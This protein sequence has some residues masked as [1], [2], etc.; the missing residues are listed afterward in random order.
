[1]PTI[2]IIAAA[3]TAAI[4]PYL[5]Q[6]LAP[7]TAA[8]LP[9]APHASGSG[10]VMQVIAHEDDDLLFMN[11][12]V[13][14]SISAGLASVT[15][16]LTAGEITG[17]GTTP[18][19]RAR[20]RQRG[21]ENAYATMAG[22]ADG[23][24]TTQR[25]WVGDVLSVNQKSIE[26][27]R[28]R[29]R[30]NVELLFMD[31]HDAS[32]QSLDAGGQEDTVVPTNGLVTVPS[33]YAQADVVAV[34]RALLQSYQPTL[35]RTQDA[36]PDVHSP[37]NVPDHPDHVAGAKFARQAAAG[38]AG[39]LYELSY[40]GYNTSNAPANLAATE[41]TRKT[42]I[43]AEYQLFDH[44]QGATAWLARQY[45]R[46]SSGTAWASTD[47]GGR[48]QLFV[49]RNGQVQWYSQADALVWTGPTQLA[50][51]GGELAPALAVGRH[52]DGRLEVFA[53]RLSD[54]HLVVLPQTSAGGAFLSSWV[55]LG[56][57]N[58]GSGMEDQVG[59]PAVAPS[60][61]G[62]LVVFVSNAG[63]G[64]SALTQTAAGAWNSAAWTA[65]PGTGVQDGL[66]AV[67]NALGRID[68]FASTRTALLH[69][70]QNVLNG[71]FQLDTAFPAVQP[72]GA[73]AAVLDATGRVEVVDLEP[74]TGNLRLT[75][76]V[77][78]TVRTWSTGLLGIG[79]TGETTAPET[80]LSSSGRVM[81]LALDRNS[82]I[83]ATSQGQQVLS[84]DPWNSLGGGVLEQPAA[85]VDSS[86]RATIGTIGSNG[87]SVAQFDVSG[88]T[89]YFSG[90]LSLG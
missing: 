56:S 84:F 42:A 8:G 40:R 30:P 32:L 66:S 6:P 87:V 26:R 35:L 57:P 53:H 83:S 28:L 39:P 2:G 31:L 79:D 24:D 63:G 21:A 44:A 55:D 90:W 69:W 64:V 71:P 34:L 15:I 52:P 23:D 46:W 9:P 76:Q 60:G 58:L 10:G 61:D 75:Y 17:D 70:F 36:E 82:G 73:P 50:N 41:V 51:A 33:H 29:D 88:N 47:P 59:A 67:T 16:Y 1:M 85:V 12:D 14:R 74:Q 77:Q 18:A 54:H 62:R 25:E 43:D 38:Y 49:V 81:L 80:V 13:D 7:P 48:A 45:Y 22:V 78:P 11:P 68:V 86:G 27:Y 65:L 4:L 5:A 37:G 72:A 89:T 20:N 3:A 19:D